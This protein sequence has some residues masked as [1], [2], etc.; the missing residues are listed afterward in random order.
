MLKQIVVMSL[1]AVGLVSCQDHKAEIE[2]Q[3]EK[4]RQKVMAEIERLDLLRK[5][6]AEFV[7]G[8]EAALSA[9]RREFEDWKSG[10]LANMRAYAEIVAKAEKDKVTESR[11]IW[12]DRELAKKPIPRKKFFEDRANKKQRVVDALDGLLASTRKRRAATLKAIAEKEPIFLKQI[13]TLE[14]DLKITQA[15]YDSLNALHTIEVG[16]LAKFGK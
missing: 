10:H 15:T 1:V 9:K 2:R 14:S 16:K 7:P 11:T 6:V 5:K 4:E 13:E 12:A 3:S 8:Q